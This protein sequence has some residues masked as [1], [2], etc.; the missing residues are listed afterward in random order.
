MA[1]LPPS[2]SECTGGARKAR[3]DSG[4]VTSVLD[5]GLVAHVSF[6]ADGQPYG[7]P[8][9]YARVEEC[10]GDVSAGS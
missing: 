1:A 5:D 8:M 4:S 3:Y 2:A 7:P 9:L 10:L 6:A